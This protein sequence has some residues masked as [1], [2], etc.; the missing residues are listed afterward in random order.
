MKGVEIFADLFLTIL[1][2]VEVILMVGIIWVFQIIY[3]VESQTGITDVFDNPRQVSLNI[4]FKP[5]KYE[6]TFLTFLELDCKNCAQKISMKEI[7][8]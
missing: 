7:M 8:L 4:L 1:I 5:S 6:S 2:V 3:G